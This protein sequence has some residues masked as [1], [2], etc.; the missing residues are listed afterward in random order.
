MET[1]IGKVIA[2]K[3]L[4]VHGA[5]AEKEGKQAGAARSSSSSSSSSS[6]ERADPKEALYKSCL[7]YTSPSPRD[8]G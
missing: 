2:G 4:D 7:L 5:A 1:A 3:H 6:K 8:R